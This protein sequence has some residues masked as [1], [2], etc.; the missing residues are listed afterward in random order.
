MTNHVTFL[1]IIRF[2]PNG[3]VL[4]VGLVLMFVDCFILICCGNVLTGFHQCL[5]RVYMIVFRWSLFHAF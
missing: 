5:T 2:Y 1:Y 4:V 3:S